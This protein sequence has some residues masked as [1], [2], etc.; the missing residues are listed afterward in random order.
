MA[1]RDHQYQALRHQ[2][3][4]PVGGGQVV[5]YRADDQ[6]HVARVQHAEQLGDQA[7]VQGEAH[8]GIA[9]AERSQGR[10][11]V[12]RPEH[13]RRTDPH[14]AAEHRTELGQVATGG[15]KLGEH[16]ARPGQEHLT[17]VCQRH[18]PGG[19]L[20]QRGAE[21]VLKP[22]DLRRH[23]RL[24]D[25]QP[26]GGLGEAAVAHHRVEVGKLPQLHLSRMIRDKYIRK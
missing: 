1:R 26:L 24:R 17:R 19:P 8:P 3:T 12:Q 13:L 15:V 25:M 14:P 20:Q 23:G 21:F 18:P 2:G 4:G 6:V 10:R 16:L 5:V 9:A 7:G 11:Q 22:S